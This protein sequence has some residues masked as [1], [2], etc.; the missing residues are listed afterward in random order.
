VGCS[1]SDPPADFPPGCLE[2]WMLQHCSAD[3]HKVTLPL[4][5][6]SAPADYRYNPR[7]TA[8]GGDIDCGQKSSD[9]KPQSFCKICDG[10]TAVADAC[11]SNPK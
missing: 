9:G 11:D 4:C 3:T 2:T 7:R 10:V 1:I 6:S 8:P 5:C